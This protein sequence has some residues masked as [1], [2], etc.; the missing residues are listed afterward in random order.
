MNIKMRQL[1]SVI[2]VRDG[3]SL[4]VDEKP[5]I[6]LA[7]EVHNSACTS[8]EYMQF[9]WE[10]AKEINCNTILA[11]V[12][13]E[14][15]EPEE[16]H[17]DHKLIHNMILDAR[18]HNLRLVLLWFGSWKNGL[19]TYVPRWIKTDFER[20]PRTEDEYGRKTRILS[21]FHSDILEVESNA[22]V[23]L[24][25]FIKEI[26]SVAQTVIAIQVEN[27]IG[28]LGSTRDWSKY[29]TEEFKR[30][31][32]TELL[33]YLEN[34][35][36]FNGMVDYE[37]STKNWKNIFGKY[38]DEVFMAW[39]YATHVNCLAKC[40]KECYRLPMFTNAW[41]KE[42]DD[43]RPGFYPSGGP[44]PE[45]LDIWKCAAPGLDFLSP[46]IYTFQFDKVAK[47]YKRNDNPLFI[48]ETRRDKWAVA[49]LYAAIGSY[50]ALCFSPFGLE[51]IGEDK[52]FI[53]QIVHTDFSDKNVS[54]TMVK[55]Y[56]SLSYRLFQNMM[57][58][59]TEYYGTD[60]MIGFVQ[61]DMQMTKHIRLSKYQITIEFYHVIDDENKY[62]PSAGIII[63]EDE[64][65][66]IFLGYGYR[67]YLETV[68]PGKQL[69]FLCL[70]KGTYDKECNWK[71]YMD[72]N[73][74]E[75]HI[76]MEEIPTVLKAV[77]YEF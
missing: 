8:P 12:Y 49:N 47:K 77:Y 63:E 14:L 29:A 55:E 66:L 72:L 35:H 20:F 3:Y 45:M 31:V 2:K 43:E 5:F 57:P 11:P 71:K 46:D 64:N 16:N 39:H 26:D 13:W 58:L 59:L 32:P 51:S 40:G 60:K 48:P 67:A 6:M 54:S 75:L 1:P 24:M 23:Q 70:E 19:S 9:V 7:A 34:V 38:A 33:E 22:F 4:L 61:R 15:F 21:M 28:V 41:L 65:K 74:D 53:T 50:H 10:K 36:T 25:K 44:L 69:D 52:S 37:D 30:T 76:R 17:Y 68:N 73:G 18:K 62:I 27:E 56:L 42:S